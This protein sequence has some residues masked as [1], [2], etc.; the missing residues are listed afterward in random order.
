MK[1]II[2][3][4]IVLFLCTILG[5]TSAFGQ[6]SDSNLIEGLL[7]SRLDLFGTVMENPAKFEVQ[8][9]YTQIDRDKNNQPSFKE[10]SYRLDKSQ[11]FYPASTVKFP[12]ALLALERVNE[13]NI[14]GFDKYSRMQ[15]DSGYR[16]Q[17]KVLYDSTAAN[18]RP[19]IAHYV[20]KLF[21]VSDNDAHNRL[22]EFVGQGYLNDKLHEKGYEDVRI[23]HRLSIGDGDERAKYTNPMRFYSGKQLVYHKPLEYNEKTYPFKLKNET[24]GKGF[25]KKDKLI[26]QPMN[27]ADKNYISLSNLHQLLKA[28]IFPEAVPEKQRFNLTNDDYKLLYK[29]MSILPRESNYPNYKKDT[30]MTDNFVKFL[31]YADTPNITNKSIRIYNKIG[32]AYGY[33]IDN[34]YIVDFKNQTEFML[35]V[36]I[37]VNE[38]QIFN[39]DKYEYDSIGFPFLAN[40]GRV[41]YDYDLKR[42]RENKPDLKRFKVVD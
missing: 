10:Y 25:Y 42:K 6:T 22:Y 40:L 13:L 41:L 32:L 34:A 36:V 24:A 8:I 28:V 39:D 14:K 27:F 29:S 2:V 18:L 33:L 4:G 19:S 20:K 37:Y 3:Q 16:E 35:S 26:E 31:I 17:T 7:K 21:I 30:T 5:V 11:Y 38:D 12:T 23:I 1:K 15:I 9:I